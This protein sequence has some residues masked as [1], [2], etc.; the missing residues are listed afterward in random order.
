MISDDTDPYPLFPGM[1]LSS[2]TTKAQPEVLLPR[3]TNP[4]WTQH[5]ALLIAKYIDYFTVVTKHGVYIDGFAGPQYQDKPDLWAAKLVLLNKPGRIRKYFLFD[6]DP[7]Q[8]KLIDAMVAELP[9]QDASDNKRKI[10]VEPGDCNVKIRE[11][12]DKKL[13]GPR[14]ATFALLD[15]RN[16][17][18]EWKTLVSLATYKPQD[19]SKI[20]LFY[21]LPSAW[22]N[23][24]AKNR[25]KQERIEEMDAWWGSDRW[26]VLMDLGPWERMLMLRER[27]EKELGYAYVTP[28]PIYELENGCGTIMYFMIHASDHP[29]APTLMRRAYGLCVTRRQPAAQMSLLPADSA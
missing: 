11:L 24:S 15:Q 9:P 25:R 20:E 14:E 29:A 22:F 13:I 4:I 1:T 8:I 21:F 5:K 23:R 12:L 2:E 28:L 3:I 16:F 19:C 10:E 6:K 7:D 18:C 27:F 17:E 26:R